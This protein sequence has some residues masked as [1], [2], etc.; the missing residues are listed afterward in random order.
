MGNVKRI[1]VAVD[2]SEF[3]NKI[4]DHAGRLAEDL[5]PSCFL[6]TSSTSVILT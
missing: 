5:G 4:T 2:F 3:S 1:M 6:S